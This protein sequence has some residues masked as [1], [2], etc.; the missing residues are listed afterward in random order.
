M[1]GSG[2]VVEGRGEGGGDGGEEGWS[3]GFVLEDLI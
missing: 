2:H 3:G 1:E